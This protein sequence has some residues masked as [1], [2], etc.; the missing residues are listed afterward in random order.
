MIVR[1]KL[2]KSRRR[3]AVRLPKSVA[4]PNDIQRVDIVRWGASLIVSPAGK[5]WADYYE[6]GPHVSEDFMTDREDWAWRERDLL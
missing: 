2:F 4:F 3:Q 1:S 6:R 5:S